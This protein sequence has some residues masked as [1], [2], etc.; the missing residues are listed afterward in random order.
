MSKKLT[1]N[2][3]CY[4]RLAGELSKLKKED[5]EGIEINPTDDML[6][7][8][9]VIKGPKDTPYENGSWQLIIR[10]T[11]EYPFKPPSVKFLDEIFHPNI[12]RD[13]KICVS[14]LQGEWSAAMNVEKILHSI[15]SL[16]MDPNTSSPANR[17]ASILYSSNYNEYCSRIIKIINNNKLGKGKK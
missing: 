6:L 12:Y 11:E 3:F 10:F 4:Q 16:L 9:A 13:G 7:W 14:I 1:N 2:S 17:E 8:G 15:S 5:L